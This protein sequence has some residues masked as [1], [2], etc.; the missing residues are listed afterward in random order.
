MEGKGLENLII[1]SQ[2]GWHHARIP[3]ATAYSYPQL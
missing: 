3:D 2:H 1:W